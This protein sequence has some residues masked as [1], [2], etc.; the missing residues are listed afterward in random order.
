MTGF[1]RLPRQ[2]DDQGD[3]GVTTP[4]TENKPVTPK[5][6]GKPAG[7]ATPAAD[8]GGANKEAIRAKVTAPKQQEPEHEAPAPEKPNGRGFFSKGIQESL[9]GGEP[10]PQ[11][12]QQ[13]E[14]QDAPAAEAPKPRARRTADKAEDAAMKQRLVA[15]LP[16]NA[17]R[18][19]NEVVRIEFAGLRPDVVK[20]AL[21]AIAAAF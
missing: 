3:A 14:E 9:G 12:A 8:S 19:D 16:E 15:S 1:K 21:A 6:W 20:A 13:A 11:T 7:A 4:Q 10:M 5:G 17:A 18:I 2:D